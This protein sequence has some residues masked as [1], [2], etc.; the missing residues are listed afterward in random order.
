MAADELKKAIQ[1]AIDDHVVTS[2]EFE[3]IMNIAEADGRID[4][5]ERTLLKELHSMLIDK[6]I[7]WKQEP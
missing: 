2:K 6:V 1:K 4:K 3:N 7:S 5:E